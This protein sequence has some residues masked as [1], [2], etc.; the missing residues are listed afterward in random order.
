MKKPGESFMTIY[1]VMKYEGCSRILNQDLP[2]T[3]SHVAASE[4]TIHVLTFIEKS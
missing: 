2:H 3:R 1:H 4:S